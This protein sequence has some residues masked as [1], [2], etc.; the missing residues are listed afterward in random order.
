MVRALQKAP[1]F[2][3]YWLTCPFT[4]D[5]PIKSTLY[6]Y[7]KLLNKWWKID[8]TMIVSLSNREILLF[9]GDSCNFTNSWQITAQ[10]C[11]QYC[12]PALANMS[13]STTRK[14]QVVQKRACKL[15]L[16]CS[17]D[18]L[19]EQM[20]LDLGWPLVRDRFAISTVNMFFRILVSHEPWTPKRDPF[21]TVPFIFGTPYH[22][23]SDLCPVSQTSKRQF[24]ICLQ[25][26][27][28]VMGIF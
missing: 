16:K 23:T 5:R 28:I 14:L 25:A 27:L 22:Q 11:T 26:R 21:S 9:W 24:T 6:V 1:Q 2:T 10:H 7:K 20:H 18:A 15:L 3:F 8:F 17:R 12:W 19:V 4:M 13:E